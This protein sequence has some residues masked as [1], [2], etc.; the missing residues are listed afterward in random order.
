[1]IVRTP[2]K[3]RRN[4]KG[5]KRTVFALYTHLAKIQVKKGSNLKH[6][7]PIGRISKTS[8]RFPCIGQRP[9]LHF[10]LSHSRDFSGKSINPNLY[11]A[12]EPG[13]ITC[14]KKGSK[15]ATSHLALT[16][17]LTCGF[18]EAKRNLAKRFQKPEF[19][20]TIHELGSYLETADA[21]Y[22]KKWQAY[23]K[24]FGHYS[25]AVDGVYGKNTHI[26]ATRCAWDTK[27]SR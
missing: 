2:F 3:V 24:L 9:H 16:S 23:F 7:T 27:C 20:G 13:E 22:I 17:P 25:G 19:D 18:D 12:N 5:K 4:N 8:K 1:M 6:G 10:E 21:E 11:W 26:A 14:Y 15:I